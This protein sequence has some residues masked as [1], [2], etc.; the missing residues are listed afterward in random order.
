MK[1]DASGGKPM[2]PTYR[3]VPGSLTWRLYRFFL[4]NPDEELT[5]RDICNKFGVQAYSGIESWLQP[6]VAKGALRVRDGEDGRVWVLGTSP[7]VVI[8]ELTAPEEEAPAAKSTAHDPFRQ[9]MAIQ[10]GAIPITRHPLS[11][12]ERAKAEMDEWL[13][14]FD[15]GCTA[16]FSIHYLEYFQGPVKEYSQ[17]TGA[18]FK[19]EPV[20]AN[21]GG[22]ER[23]S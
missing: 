1:Q 4:E 15:V 2:F 12:M 16:V 22:I 11:A 6:A 8:A 17:R 14:R 19:L 5:R 23:V 21:R 18:K 10:V 20:D 3:P 7:N 9:T 13:G